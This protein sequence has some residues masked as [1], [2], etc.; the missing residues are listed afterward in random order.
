MA[1]GTPQ[2]RGVEGCDAL[3][4]FGGIAFGQ[5]AQT[6]IKRRVA[7]LAQGQELME[8][9]VSHAQKSGLDGGGVR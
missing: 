3:L 1:S 5:P 4:L 2:W 6:V 7:T 8:W 9:Q